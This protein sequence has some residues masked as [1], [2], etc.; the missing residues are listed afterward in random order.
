MIF[1]ELEAG[2]AELETKPH[3]RPDIS[4]GAVDVVEVLVDEFGVTD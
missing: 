4:D 3:Q 2:M 1:A